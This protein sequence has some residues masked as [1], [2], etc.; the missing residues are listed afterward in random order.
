MFD[1]LNFGHDFLKGW[2]VTLPCLIGALFNPHFSLTGQFGQPQFLDMVVFKVKR[3]KIQRSKVIAKELDLGGR[4]KSLK[5]QMQTR[6]N[7]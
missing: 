1:G 5:S 2:E 3:N 7:S 6:A 4:S